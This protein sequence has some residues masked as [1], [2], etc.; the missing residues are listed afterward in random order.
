MRVEVMLPDM[1][2]DAESRVIVS[3]WLV[4]M[5]AH[6]NEGEDLIELT[7]DKAAFTLPAPQSGVVVEFCVDA[8]DVIG[9]GEVICVLEI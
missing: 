9:V 7:T 4:E 3:S 2:E 8:D 1:G 6:V 5:G